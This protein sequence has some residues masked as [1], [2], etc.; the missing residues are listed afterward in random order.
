MANIFEK[1]IDLGIGTLIY[2]REKIEEM[3]DKLVNKGEI[4]KKDAHQFTYDLVKKGEEQ[5]A[6]IKS[7]VKDEVAEV[8]NSM[9]IARKED[10]V[11]KDEIKDIIKEQLKIAF[12]D[13]KAMDENKVE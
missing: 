4:A 7:I 3:V 11:S 9:N 6:Q 1:S 5:R 10:I 8:L 13:L 2:S 12:N